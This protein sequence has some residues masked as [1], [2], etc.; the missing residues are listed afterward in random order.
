M[1]L[2]VAP[3]NSEAAKKQ[4]ERKPAQKLNLNLDEPG[5]AAINETEREKLDFDFDQPS[6]GEAN[7]VQQMKI[8]PEFRYTMDNDDYNSRNNEYDRQIKLRLNLDF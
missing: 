2:I 6:R 4:A 7:I 1:I 3:V 5:F 8:R